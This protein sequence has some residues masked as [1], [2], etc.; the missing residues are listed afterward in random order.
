MDVSEE[1]EMNEL[2]KEALQ[3]GLAL[4]ETHT[5]RLHAIGASAAEQNCAANERDLIAAALSSVEAKPVALEV[6]FGSM[7]ESNGRENWTV[8]LRRKAAPSDASAHDLHRLMSG[9]S[10]YRSEY[11]DRARYEADRLRFLLGDLAEA[12]HILDYDADLHS[13][14][15]A[16]LASVEAQA[17]EDPVSLGYL[18]DVVREANTA[19]FGNS[20]WVEHNHITLGAMLRGD[21]KWLAIAFNSDE[22]V[23]RAHDALRLLEDAA[24]RAH[25]AAPQCPQ[26]Q[27]EPSPE[28]ER[29][30]SQESAY[31]DGF[32]DGWCCNV[33]SLPHDYVVDRHWENSTTARAA[34]SAEGS[35]GAQ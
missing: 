11:K 30:R 21:R 2:L 6:W 15:A 5:T 24:K 3:A 4:A 16:P 13:G 17:V 26:P 25:A 7:P 20:T 14:Y 23:L 31:R 9:V 8:T 35:G 34:L 33:D 10:V 29:H 1:N 12:P 19:L 22:E 32:I 27:A 18:R 28:V